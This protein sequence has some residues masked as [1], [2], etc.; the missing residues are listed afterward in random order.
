MITECP[1]QGLL[2]TSTVICHSER[3]PVSGTSEESPG[4]PEK[5]L[6]PGDPSPRC[7]GLRMTIV[8]YFN[9]SLFLRKER[10]LRRG[11][12]RNDRKTRFSTIC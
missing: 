7:A 12:T 9:P 6:Y 3:V 8:V 11:D 1:L 4:G 10:R 5:N 2:M